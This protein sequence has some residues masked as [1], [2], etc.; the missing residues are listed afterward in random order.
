MQW[1]NGTSRRATI[2]RLLKGK[3]SP[4]TESY[5]NDSMSHWPMSQ[6]NAKDS[7]A[8]PRGFATVLMVLF[9]LVQ[10]A[11]PVAA[12]W[13][14]VDWE[15]AQAQVELDDM[16]VCMAPEIGAICNDRVDVDDVTTGGSWV[17]GMYNFN[18]TS[19]TTLEFQ[20]SWAIREWDMSNYAYFQDDMVKALLGQGGVDIDAGDGLPSDVLRAVFHVSTDADDPSAQTVQQAML[21][22]INNTV[23]TFLLDWDE[24]GATPAT[25]W[26]EQI[27]LDG[28]TVTCSSD[29]EDNDAPDENPQK[30]NA[31]EPPICI[32]T[33]VSITLPMSTYG[34]QVAMLGSSN[35]NS[36]FEGLMAMGTTV[37]T[38]FTVSVDPGFKGTYAIHP[39]SYATILE[40]QG[41][42]PSKVLNDVGDPYHSGL[43]EVD[44]LNPPGGGAAEAKPGDMLLTMG[45][46]ETNTTSV[47]NIEEGAKSLDLRVVL[48]LSDEQ[49]SSV[50]VTVG[51][52]QISS[53]TLESWGINL[54][55]KETA[56]IPV[57]TSDGIRMAHATG[58]LNAD[59]LADKLPLSE[60]G[61]AIAGLGSIGGGVSMG[62][63]QWPT[64][65]TGPQDIGGLDHVHTP[66]SCLSGGKYCT[67]GPVAMDDTYPVYITT[68]SHIFPL[69]LASLL[70]GNLGED[71]GFINSV[72][73]DDLGKMLNSGVEFSTTLS[74]EAMDS[75]VGSML[76]AGLSA[77]LALEIILPTWAST[78][79]GLPSIVL[80][81]RGV[82]GEHDSEISLTG[83][84][85]FDWEHPICSSGASEC[86]DSSED[87]YCTS[88]MKS[89]AR[90]TVDLDI[91]DI[92][93]A[94]L[95]LTKSVTVEFSLE[96]NLSVHRIG[97]P[98]SMLES[99]N[100]DTMNLTLE[101]L[102]ADLLKLVANISGR[103][104]SAPL[105]HEFDICDTGQSFCT[106]RIEFSDIG[107]TA[108]AADFGQGVTSMLHA[109]AD[110][111]QYNLDSNFCVAGQC[112]AAGK[113][114]LDAFSVEAELIGITDNDTAVGDEVPITLSVRIPMV[115]ITM[116]LD[117]SWSELIA[118]AQGDSVDFRLGVDTSVPTNALVAP[119][120]N[121]V[122]G[123]MEGLTGA[124]SASLITSD[125]ISPPVTV[126]QPTD[127]IPTTLNEE[128]GLELIGEIKVRLPL[129]IVLENLDSK[130]GQVTHYREDNGF[131]RQVIIYDLNPGEQT[132]EVSFNPH[133]GWNW[134]FGQLVYYFGAIVL[135]FMWRV[136]SRRV[137]KKRKR[138]KME[139]EQL[140][141]AAETSAQIYVAPTPT[142][143]VLAV[144]EN[145]IVVKR[146]LATG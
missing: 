101:V 119:F 11:S 142:V 102:P 138:R 78:R 53:S 137:K 40:V 43:W 132:D 84:D 92:S 110:S 27:F 36:A 50:E 52:Y 71:A 24:S 64:V 35:L 63:P 59:D 4:E 81:Y 103:G 61:T 69:S 41:T 19:P 44:N 10:T 75:L 106:Q 37:S 16:L 107:L 46:R 130:D 62:D 20:A 104:D 115:R 32:S 94:N 99:I 95:P 140:E 1:T 47:V 91:A 85:S 114:D 111:L 42:G 134:V 144:A 86:S 143:E 73:G 9:F 57:I 128:M 70:G 66:P 131:G 8:P 141:L 89:C 30:D 76:P 96:V 98:E 112:V 25:V 65:T 146:R 118:I 15:E 105:S 79:D 116:G 125:G 12:D 56:S 7:D 120:L 82:S 88:T 51:I 121:P 54:M 3:L 2:R 13:D 87:A 90:T 135:F 26:S 5:N 123:A 48:D 55:P 83:S 126:S 58:L 124:L 45:F 108:F 38:D 14:D 6:R 72:T 133:I 17:E 34:S 80:T 33:M 139:L 23:S 77:D 29:K 68:A 74:D 31:F 93:L 129:G 60:I 18:M 113:M 109:K 49:S 117:N 136:R 127:V 67:E 100:S 21:A 39:P 145:G 122:I 97:I 28:T 22:E